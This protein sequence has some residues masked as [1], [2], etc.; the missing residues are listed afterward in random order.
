MYQIR[1]LEPAARD[2]RR[3]DKQVSRRVVSRICWLAENVEH[4]QMEALAGDLAGVLQ[5]ARG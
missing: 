3:L 5:A 1:I 4:I 2:L